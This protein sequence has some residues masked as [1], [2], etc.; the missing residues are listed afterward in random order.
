MLCDD[1]TRVRG[2][3]E[4]K[5]GVRTR[6]LVRFTPPA[7]LLAMANYV[8]IPTHVQLKLPAL[9]EKPERSRIP[10]GPMKTLYK[11]YLV[12][13]GAERSH[14]YACMHAG[15]RAGMHAS[16][17]PASLPAKHAELCRQHKKPDK[18]GLIAPGKLRRWQRRTCVGESLSDCNNRPAPIRD[19]I[20]EVTATVQPHRGG[21]K[22][23]ER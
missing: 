10:P 7:A 20:G 11:T 13:S 9:S 22:L 8:L 23:H 15:V 3:A 12:S 4:A 6:L 5:R 14:M 21:K 19:L 2:S 17:Q 18:I 16:Y 1:R